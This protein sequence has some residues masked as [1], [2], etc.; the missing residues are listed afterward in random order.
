MDELRETIVSD[1]ANEK[2]YIR[3]GSGGLAPPGRHVCALY[4]KMGFP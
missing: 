4:E 1:I 3:G 2:N